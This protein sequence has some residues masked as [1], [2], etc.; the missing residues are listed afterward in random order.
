MSYF[1]TAIKYESLNEQSGKIENVKENFLL[2]AVNFSDAEL[3]THKYA[4]ENIGRIEFFLES[5]KRSNITE[6]IQDT[7]GEHSTN[8]FKIGIKWIQIN[9][10]TG[11]ESGDKTIHIVNANDFDHARAIINSTFVDVVAPYEISSI[12]E[13]KLTDVIS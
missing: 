12:T 1:E 8:W 5:I 10:K 11:K 13:I 2:Q 7:T 4:N 3:Q 9:E 6:V